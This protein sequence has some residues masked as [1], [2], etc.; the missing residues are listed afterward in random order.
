MSILFR[1]VRW[2]NFLSTGNLFTEV[3]LNSSNVT[4]VIGGNGS[5]KCVRKNTE[6]DIQFSDEETKQKYL[7]YMKSK[8]KL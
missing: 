1:K 4:L 3:D 8:K 5:G 7:E 6:I 2:K